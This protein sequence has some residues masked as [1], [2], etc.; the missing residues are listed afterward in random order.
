MNNVQ[1]ILKK[2]NNKYGIKNVSTAIVCGSGLADSIPDLDNKKVINYSDLKMPK[3]KVKGHSDSFIFGDLNGKKIM[4][5]SR[6]H[7]YESGDISKVRMP[8]E[9]ANGLGVKTAIL[10]TS[11][12]GINKSFNVGDIMLIEDMINLS[13]VNP[14]VGIDN[15]KFV[16]MT[17]CFDNTLRNKINDICKSEEIDLK[18]GTHV[19]MSGPS[20]ETKAEIQMI[21][22]LGG[23]TVSMSTVHD[24]IIANYYDMKVL[25]FSV[26]VNIFND[27]NKKLSHQEVLANAQSVCKRL[28]K[29]LI[30]FI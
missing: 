27:D 5:I 11:S 15:I 2:L 17:N 16:D 4:I 3:S 29:I 7:F 14:L 30:S 20:Y 23:D 25:G 26:I 6:K 9:I 12:G 1:K 13:G 19:Q 10:L 18:C 21:K 24:C 22:S 28:K 8:L